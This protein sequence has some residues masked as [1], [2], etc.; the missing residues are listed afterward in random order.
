MA[1]SAVPALIDAMVT[2]F[3]AALPN[4]RV[5]YGPG[6]SDDPGDYLMVGVDNPDEPGAFV[7]SASATAT[8][9][10]IGNHARDQKGS[11]NC[12][13]WSW[14]GGSDNASQKAAVEAAYAT[15][16]AVDAYVRANPTLGVITTGWA[17]HATD[18]HLSMA[19]DSSGA[20]ARVPFQ[21]SF[22]ARL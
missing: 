16:A 3:T 6:V 14:N 18:E 10:G 8:W 4:I 9:V 1:T 2:A 15:I 11:I 19:Q 12:V 7:D 5:Y 22:Q 20:Q 13:A 17:I 21:I